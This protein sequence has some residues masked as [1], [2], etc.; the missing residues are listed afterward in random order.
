MW[1]KKSTVL[2]A[3]CSGIWIW[4]FLHCVGAFLSLPLPPPCFLT[5]LERA[6]E[7]PESFSFTNSHQWL[8]WFSPNTGHFLLRGDGGGCERAATL[9]LVLLPRC[10]APLLRETQV[11]L[12]KTLASTGF[13]FIW[14]IKQ[15]TGTTGRIL[16][17]D[18][19]EPCLFHSKQARL[20][21]ISALALM[22]YYL[23][24][25]RILVFNIQNKFT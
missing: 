25:P 9:Q 10:T 2:K 22:C 12:T 16:T 6:L 8:N 14:E 11:T 20:L 5:V 7:S 21:C 23:N 19:S 15:L 3:K 1:E 17:G 18:A 24:A 4:L 13:F